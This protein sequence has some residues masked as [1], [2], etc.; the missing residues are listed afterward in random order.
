MSLKV[1]C[2]K[3]NT[4]YNLPK[5]PPKKTVATCKKCG[6]LILIDPKDNENIV[7]LINQADERTS[8]QINCLECGK[9]KGFWSINYAGHD[10]RAYSKHPFPERIKELVLPGD[11][12]KDFLCE[13]CANKRE[14]ECTTHG[15]L[16]NEKFIGGLPPICT[17]CK[18]EHKSMKRELKR[19]K[20]DEA[21]EKFQNNLDAQL[22]LIRKIIKEK[23]GPMTEDTIKNDS[24]IE[25][26]LR[27]I[28]TILPFPIRLLCN[29]DKFIE[30]ILPLKDMVF[31]EN[32]NIKQNL[33]QGS[34]FLNENNVSNDIV[35]KIEKLSELYKNGVLTEEEF[36][37]KKQDLLS[38]L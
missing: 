1:E 29:E 23:I 32:N 28:Y 5:S 18:D 26:S 14:A 21:K 12:T 35:S 20:R 31:D 24:L 3:C 13:H 25:K 11:K 27:K 33:E 36:A 6:G 38:R 4:K 17:K 37:Q 9:K 34:T 22:P 19:V 7:P 16:K 30:Y 8:D 10:V 2:S 15:Q